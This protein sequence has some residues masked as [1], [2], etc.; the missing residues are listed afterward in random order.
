MNQNNTKNINKKWK[1]TSRQIMKYLATGFFSIKMGK[2]KK[3][4]LSDTF[5][6]SFYFM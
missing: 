4:K 3:S 2:K 6:G 5:M 1:N